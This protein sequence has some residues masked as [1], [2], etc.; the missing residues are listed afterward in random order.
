MS[1]SLCLMHRSFSLKTCSNELNYFSNLRGFFIY[2]FCKFKIIKCSKR[3]E[4]AL[5]LDFKRTT[6]LPYMLQIH[7]SPC[8]R[9]KQITAAVPIH[10]HP[11]RSCLPSPSPRITTLPEVVLIL[12][13]TINISFLCTYIALKIPT[14]FKFT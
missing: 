10:P 4:T 11:P 5:N 3:T 7:F 6:I 13:V 14:I 2:I 12:F 9:K 8:L 1:P